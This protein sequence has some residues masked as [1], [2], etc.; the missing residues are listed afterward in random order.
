MAAGTATESVEPGDKVIL[1]VMM[2]KQKNKVVYGEAG[3]DF[4][5]ALLSFLTMPLGTVARL[6]AKD[7][8]MKPVKFGS[9]SSL[10]R[11]LSDLNEQY[12]WSRNYKEMLLNPRNSMRGYCE[13]V[14]LNIDDT[15]TN[16]FMCW[17]QLCM[18]IF[19]NQKCS[20]GNYVLGSIMYNLIAMMTLIALSV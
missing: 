10:Y 16:V 3:K 2:D 7:S 4:V 15:S 18:S 8:N 5:E 11:S 13:M 20:C 6:V 12:L 1:R 14:K 19:S 9:V 17:D